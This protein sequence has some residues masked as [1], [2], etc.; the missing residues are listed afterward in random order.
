MLE[1]R[2]SSCDILQRYSRQT[3][4]SCYGCSEFF[5]GLNSD[6]K[7]YQVKVIAK[8]TNPSDSNKSVVIEIRK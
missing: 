4:S 3:H 1:G 7:V 2:T 6:S 8:E 5:F